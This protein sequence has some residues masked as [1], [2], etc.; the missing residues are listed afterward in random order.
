MAGIGGRQYKMLQAQRRLWRVETSKAWSKGLPAW[1]K[2]SGSDNKQMLANGLKGCNCASARRD[3]W[4]YEHDTLAGGVGFAGCKEDGGVATI[5]GKGDQA[6]SER[7]LTHCCLP[8]EF[9]S[10]E[11]PGKCK[12]KGSPKHTLT[13]SRGADGG[14]GGH[15]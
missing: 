13:V 6:N 9:A 3:S 2:M 14:E 8:S 1:R 10:T 12:A 5:W 7:G 4:C 15:T 11:E